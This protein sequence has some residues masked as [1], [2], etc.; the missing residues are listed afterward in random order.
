MISGGEVFSDIP[1]LTRKAF[2]HRTEKYIIFVMRELSRY[3]NDMVGTKHLV[4]SLTVYM[5]H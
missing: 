2:R 3:L 4:V 1:I 5:V